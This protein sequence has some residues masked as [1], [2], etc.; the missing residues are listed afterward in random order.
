M[1]GVQIQIQNQLIEISRARPE[2]KGVTTK[3]YTTL[4]A[5][6]KVAYAARRISRRALQ[7]IK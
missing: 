3:V 1:A 6:T 4:H 7:Q 5:L 2:E